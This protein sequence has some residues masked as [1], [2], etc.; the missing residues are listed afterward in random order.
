LSVQKLYLYR[1]RQATQEQSIFSYSF[2][3]IKLA[4]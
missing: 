4:E 1:Y 3:S 2:I